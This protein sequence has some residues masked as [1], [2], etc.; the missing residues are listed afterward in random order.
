M[1]YTKNL[2][3]RKFNFKQFKQQFSMKNDASQGPEYHFETFL[4][5]EKNR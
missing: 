3:N 4:D 5:A 1:F 2:Q